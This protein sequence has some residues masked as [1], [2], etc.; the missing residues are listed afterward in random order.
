MRHTP[1]PRKGRGAASNRVSRFETWVREEADDGWG[2]L[3]EEPAPLDTVLIRD[4]S[5][6]IIARNDS[7]DIPFDRSINPYRGCEHGCVYCFARPS[8]AY[9]GYSPGL[10]FESRILYKPK[11]AELLHGELGKRS[12]R[13]ATMALGANTDP[14]QPA[15]RRLGITRQILEVL[16]EHRHP[17]GIVTK[18]A[19]IERDLDLLQ[20]LAAEGL[21][22]VSV[23]VTTLD[24]A[25]ARRLEPR[26]AAPQRR[27]E[28]IGTLSAAGIPVGVL[29]APVIPMLND[30]EM[31]QVL[32]AAREAGSL[33]AG[34]VLLRLPLEIADLFQEWLNTHYPLKAGRVMER[35]KDTR[36]GKTYDSAFG[37]RM[38]G[39]GAYAEL[40]AKRF[41]LA[42]KRLDF[43]GFPE[44]RTVLFKPP[45]PASPQMGLFD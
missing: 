25:L 19:L 12:Y 18:S 20:A 17:V 40:I 37:K 2:N 42:V 14:Y 16:L 11:A 21:V 7:P 10:D 38:Q 33:S 9:L 39:T 29:F 27:L 31:E 4:A 45:G 15:E 32:A 5:R 8:H 44:L 1:L 36:G 28:T 34:Y 22:H 41:R 3:D 24:R 26:A 30:A 43:P 6:S 23:S 13:C 35:I